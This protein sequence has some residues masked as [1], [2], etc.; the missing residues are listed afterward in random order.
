MVTS[1]GEAIRLHC[2][3]LVPSILFTCYQHVKQGAKALSHINARHLRGYI[4]HK[5][6]QKKKKKREIQTL[7]HENLMRIHP[8]VG[9]TN[10]SVA[11]LSYAAL[12]QR[13][14]LYFPE[15][16]LEHKRETK[17]YD[18]HIQTFKSCFITKRNLAKSRYQIHQ[19]FPVSVKEWMQPPYSYRKKTNKKTPQRKKTNLKRNRLC[20]GTHLQ[21][22]LYFIQGLKLLPARNPQQWPLSM[23]TGIYFL[24]TILWRCTRTKQVTCRQYLQPSLPLTRNFCCSLNK[25][26]LP[27][28]KEWT[29]LK[30]QKSSCN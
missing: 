28:L 15:M 2:L 21:W 7:T 24:V 9:L 18:S 14:P 1:S 13:H 30:T 16:P 10:F 29:L 4:I 12:E 5:V 17:I 23:H 19:Y 20:W 26:L 11:S 3:L 27:F 25:K 22:L 6:W 8:S